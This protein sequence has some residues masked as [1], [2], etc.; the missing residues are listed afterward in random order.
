[1]R[2]RVA[3]A[4]LLAGLCL[5]AYEPPVDTAG[6]LTVRIQAPAAGSYGSGGFLE[7][8]QPDAPFTIPVS[9]ENTGQVPLQGTLRLAVVDRWKAEPAGPVPF[10]LGPRS[11]TRLEFVVRFGQGTFNAHYP[12]HAFAEFEYQGRRLVAHPIL[13]LTTR[14][15]NPPRAP[16]PVAWR[17]VEV[18]EKGAL[19]LWRLPVHR[20][21]AAITAEETQAGATGREIFESTP[22]IQFGVRALAGQPREGLR[23]VLGMRPP[24]MRERVDAALIEYPLALP[25]NPPLRLQFAGAVSNPLAGEGATFA[26]RVLAFDAPA[27]QQGAVLLERRVTGKAWQDVDVDLSR[28]AGQSIRLGLEARAASTGEVYWA[29]PAVIAGTAPAPPAFPPTAAEKSRLLGTAGGYQVRLWPGNRGVLDAAVGFV[30]GPKRLLFRGFRATVAGDAL[31]QF[32]SASQLLEAREEPA[33]GRYRVRHRFR[34]WAGGFDLL[35]EL[36]VEKEGLQARFWLENTPPPRPWLHVCLEEVAAGPWSERALRVYGGPG[37]VIQEPQ[38]FRLGFDGH[39]LATSFVGFDF[40][41]GVSLLQGLDAT[42]DRLEVDPEARI[43]SLT[44]PHTQTMTFLPTSNVWDAVKLW[45]DRNGL[46]ASGGVEKL[47]GRFVFDLWSGRYGDSARA[48]G[49]AFRYGLT[50]SVVIWHNWQR[51][52][53]DFRLPDIYPPNPQYGALE[54]FREL[55]RVCREHG[56]LFAPHDN[57]IDFYP[58]AEGFSYEDIA[59][60][61]NGQPRRAW[62]NMGR[63]AQSYRGRADRVRPF[64]E[65]NLRLIREGFN[66]TAY[67]IDVWS[68]IAPYDYWTHDGQFIERA[69]TRKVWGESFAWIRDFLGDHAPQISEA[70]HDQLIGWLDGAQAN[71]LRVDPNARGFAWNIRSADAERIPWIDAAYHDRFILHGAGYQDRYAAGLDLKTHGMYSDDYMATEALTGRPAMVSMPFS[72]DVV[73]KYWLL[74]DVMRGLARRRI[75][76]VE[77]AGGNLHRQRVRWDNG[78][79]VWVNRGSGDWQAGDHILPQYGFYARVPSPHG[80]IETAVEKRAGSTVEWARSPQFYY[81]NARGQSV[82]LGALETSGACR[83]SPEGE[84][85]RVT[86]AP[87]SGA[88]RVLLRWSQLPWKLPEPR[89]AEAL[90]ESGNVLNTAPLGRVNGDFLLDYAPGVFAYRLR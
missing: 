61:P 29:E 73:R 86:A 83:L 38:A 36:W 33:G 75:E 58:D 14:M 25:K 57:Y 10:S 89:Q 12:V 77:F 31:D 39:N 81:A 24:S 28:F 47:A 69:L 88:F 4:I 32:R 34:N 18:P 11:R 74:H 87:D 22:A 42:P 40:A 90:D 55:V 56:V 5:K 50:D 67:F 78:A 59:F 23:M 60:N 26:V 71:Q 63:Q 3:L 54:E 35:A 13:I 41:N 84:A 85:L 80:L 62:F 2:H 52:G 27:G 49:R 79:E 53:Y 9:L 7:L 15:P 51:W 21:R 6:P 43:Y 65:R 20:Q 16:L 64:V 8:A 68:S 48:L 72:R 66:P 45:R 37:N 17:P 76:E 44:T 70:G 30:N 1:M 46:N 19:G 82:S